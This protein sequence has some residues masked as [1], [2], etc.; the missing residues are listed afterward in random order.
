VDKANIGIETG[1]CICL[2]NSGKA[3]DLGREAGAGNLP[4]AL[5]LA[6]GRHGKTGL[7]D[8][9]AELIELSGNGKFFFRS[10]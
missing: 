4:D 6:L 10:E 3:A 9:H 5:E 2:D 7:D 8:V 1:L